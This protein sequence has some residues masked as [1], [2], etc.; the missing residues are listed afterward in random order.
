MVFATAVYCTKSGIYIY[1]YSIFNVS[2]VGFVLV[3][4]FQLTV[5]SALPSPWALLVAGVA[6]TPCSSTLGGHTQLVTQ[7]VLQAWV[8][9]WRTDMEITPKI[10]WHPLVNE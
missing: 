1:I 9:F 8:Y 6:P 7:V 4:V 2:F 3:L 5:G 10:K